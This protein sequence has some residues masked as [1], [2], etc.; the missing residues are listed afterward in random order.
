M[1]RPPE[2]RRSECPGASLH[3]GWVIANHILV[4]FHV[5][6]I[7]SVL[8]LPTAAIM[9]GEILRFI[10]VS[11][12]TLISGLFL[13]L[14]FHSGIALHE[15]GHFLTAARLNVLKDSVLLEA[16]QRMDKPLV[17]RLLY[18]ARL[19]LFAPYGSAKGIRREGLNYYPDAPYNLAVAAAGPRTSGRVA[20][21]FL[22]L[23]TILLVLGLALHS[24]AA[25]YAGR[26]LLG[27]G[28][29]SLLDFLL[30]DPGKYREFRGQERSAHKRAATVGATSG[31]H[32][33]APRVKQRMTANRT[34]EVIHKRLGPVTAPWQFRNC[35]MGGRHTEKEYPESNISM[36]EAMFLI[37]GAQ[38]YQEAQE[39][40]V[41]LQNRL[42][43]II[44]KE[45]GGRV[46]GI[47]L[48]GGLAPYIEKEGYP[49]PE[50]R[51]WAMMKQA[52]ADCGYR[53]GVDVAVALDPAMSELEIAYRREFNMPD[54]VGTYLFWR[55]KAKI[56]LDRDA[57]HDVYLKAMKEYDIPIISIEDGFSEN[58][59]EGWRKLLQALGDRIFIVGDDLATTNDRTIEFSARA[60]LMNAVLI[61]PNQIGT[62]FETLMAMV[63]ALG[64]GLELVVSHRS[65]SPNDDMEAHI[66]LA[67]NALGLKAGGGAN[68]ERLVKYQSVAELLGNA[69][70]AEDLYTLHE[71]HR[72]VIQKFYAYEEP[73]N[74]GVP[75]VGTTVEFL[76]PDSGVLLRFRGATPLGTSAGTGEALHLVDG[77]VE[78]ADHREIL[79][80]HPSVFREMEPGVYSFKRDFTDVELRETGDEALTALFSR[81]RRYQGKGC[82]NA[83][84]NVLDT[85]APAFQGKDA[86]GLS[87]KDIDGT[88]LDMELQMA[89]LR[90]KLG[91]EADCDERTAVMQRKQNLGMNA[92][93]SVS[94]AMARGVAHLRGQQLYEILREE[95]LS[96]IDDLARQYQVGVAGCGF[97]DHVVALRQVNRVLEAQGKPLHEA[98]REVTGIYAGAAC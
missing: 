68:T 72:A 45:E 42:K 80:K 64:K 49:L 63:V 35:G 70:M 28:V 34:Q 21:L 44:E 86:A 84:D 29:V 22:P 43:E 96:I 26:L 31:W 73:T 16:R 56:V 11:H 23:A 36:Q 25:I 8:A 97:P 83:V 66:A 69:S 4:S 7:S 2:R 82:L 60:G 13:Y 71:G 20:F 95:M 53:P 19:F 54:A 41:R 50:V 9:K 65:K 40:T 92:V 38:D 62:L 74:A 90:G 93:L 48:E 6:F 67:A 5:A 89:R 12:E 76:L 57:V 37:L 14:S 33:V 58:D 24:Q 98:V 10:F 55:D 18:Y 1:P 79:T 46:M 3:K 17:P 61:K 59:H 75:T 47:G 87:L 78:S 51:L 15:L 88:L 30:A 39:I 32:D 77:L 27:I 94:L 85:I 52:I 91:Q 81:A